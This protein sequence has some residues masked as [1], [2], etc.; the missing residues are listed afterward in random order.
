M[1]AFRRGRDR[2]KTKLR[3]L[4]QR[5]GIADGPGKLFHG[6]IPG[7]A[8]VLSSGWAGVADV[9]G[10]ARRSAPPIPLGCN[11]SVRDRGWWRRRHATPGL[12][13]NTYAR[14]REGRLAEVAETVGQNLRS[15]TGSQRK[16]A[17]LVS[18]AR[19]D[20]KVAEAAGIEPAS[21]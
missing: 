18:R 11:S 16:S 6:F 9:D 19:A 2:E 17:Q 14:A 12:T 21:G 1:Y 10:L 3:K 13:L 5:E 4:F 8:A 7:V 15:T 20:D